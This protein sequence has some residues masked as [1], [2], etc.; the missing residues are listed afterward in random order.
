MKRCEARLANSTAK[1][2]TEYKRIFSKGF[3]SKEKFKNDLD[4]F[5]RVV[6]LDSET[7]SAGNLNIHATLS[8]KETVMEAIEH[9]AV[10][11]ERASLISAA[12]AVFEFRTVDVRSKEVAQLQVLVA[13]CREEATVI[14][15]KKADNAI[16]KVA[17][18]VAENVRDA[19]TKTATYS[20][21]A[22]KAVA[23]AKGKQARF[24][25]SQ[26]PKK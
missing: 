5:K 24:V 11:A 21:I 8:P 23:D 12:N 9:S 10:Q 1:E 18:I 16:T 13:Q 6:F 2:E 3:R 19:K 7:C 20:A 4:E 26:K 25:A 15:D 14:A 22:A 17:T